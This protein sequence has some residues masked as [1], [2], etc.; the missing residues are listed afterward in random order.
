[1]KAEQ[2]Q[3]A[4]LDGI[5]GGLELIKGANA[6]ARRGPELAIGGRFFEI[7]E[8]FVD[9]AVVARSFFQ[10]LRGTC[11]RGEDPD[12]LSTRTRWV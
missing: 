1:M 3:L 9:G 8:R 10:D 5:S 11:S 6:K 4:H 12:E 7:E 2:V